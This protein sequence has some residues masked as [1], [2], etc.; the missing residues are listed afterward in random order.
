MVT[1][2][3]SMSVA[4]KYTNT[5]SMAIVKWHTVIMMGGSKDLLAFALGAAALPSIENHHS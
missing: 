1:Y 3:T 5:E 2:T 4:H